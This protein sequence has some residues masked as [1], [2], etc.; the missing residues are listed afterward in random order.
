MPENINLEK[1]YEELMKKYNLPSFKEI[2]NLLEISCFQ[3]DLFLT[4]NIRRSIGDRL[5]NYAKII[6]E[7][8][9]PDAN[10]QSL[11]ETG[12]LTEQERKSLLQLFKHLMHFIRFENEL[13]FANDEKK[14]AEFIMAY[15]NAIPKINE[16]LIIIMQ[17]LKQNWQHFEETNENI[18]YLG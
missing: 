16:Q 11:A 15:L 4:R 3:T 12:Y 13:E 8:L 17:K 5:E 14:D 18:E 10:M 7:L 6:N 9:Q 2:D 1:K